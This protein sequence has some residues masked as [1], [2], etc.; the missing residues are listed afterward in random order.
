M[1][2]LINSVDEILWCYHSNET[3]LTE[4]LHSAKYFL[5]LFRQKDYFLDFVWPLFLVKGLRRLLINR[6]EASVKKKSAD[7][8]R[9]AKS[10]MW[11]CN[12][13]SLSLFN[14][15]ETAQ[16]SGHINKIPS[17]HSK[18]F[19]N[20]TW[21]Q[22]CLSTRWTMGSGLIFCALDSWSRSWGFDPWPGS[23][24]CIFEKT[25]HLENGFISPINEY[26][27]I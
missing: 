6:I 20:T 25:L 15:W 26:R 10:T 21:Q 14:L 17:C 19:L 2:R 22:F 11:I 24:Y 8:S 3:F 7:L 13:R 1:A 27:Q 18:P 12:G 16:N 4:L 5:G 9:R 23:L